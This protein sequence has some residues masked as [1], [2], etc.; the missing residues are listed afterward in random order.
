MFDLYAGHDYELRLVGGAVRDLILDRVPKDY[1]FCTPALPEENVRILSD[2]GVHVIETGLK[3]G[4]VTAVI[5]HEQYE[6]TTLRVDTNHDGRWAEVEY[7]DDW[8]LDAERRD[9]TINAMMLSLDGQL[10]DYFNGLEDAHARR[11]QFVGD[12]VLRISEDYL[13]ILRYFRFHGRIATGP[14]HQPSHLVAISGNAAGLDGISG[15]RVWSEMY[16]ILELDAAPHLV[17]TM[18]TT[19]VLAHIH[20]SHVTEAHV[21]ELAR[22]KSSVVSGGGGIESEREHFGHAPTGA[23]G[24]NFAG[25]SYTGAAKTAA[26]APALLAALFDDADR[27]GL[28]SLAA[29][30]H[31]SK[32]EA[33]TAA[34]VLEHRTIQPSL[35]TAQDWLVDRVPI[36]HV[37]QLL[38]YQGAA[39]IA[40]ELASWPVPRLPVDGRMLRQ[41]GVKPG[42]QMGEII[43]DMTQ[44]W[45]SS[46][47]TL[48]AEQLLEGLSSHN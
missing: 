34:F 10:Y 33:R 14:E 22:A 46:R 36:H 39:D 9:L 47:F 15:E 32:D 35:L 16:K 11:V 37:T 2:A 19:N 38:Y 18:R 1:D 42:P 6:I 28:E 25:S 40:T 30:W 12:P 44:L 29:S 26:G 45:K 23:G 27:E 7:T 5:D 13:R 41:H 20:L 3:H 4:T 21:R 8:R 48:T 31:L 24:S 17:E 43:R